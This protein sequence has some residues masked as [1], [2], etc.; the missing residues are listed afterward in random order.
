M[1]HQR[2]QAS[3][4]V[5]IRHQG[6]HAWQRHHWLATVIVRQHNRLFDFQKRKE[7]TWKVIYHFSFSGT[8]QQRSLFFSGW[9]SKSVAPYVEKDTL[10]LSMTG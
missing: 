8:M 3:N 1:A 10:T 2:Q 9:K 5:V 4:M 6:L 7:K